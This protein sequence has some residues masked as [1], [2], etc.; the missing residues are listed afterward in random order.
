MLAMLVELLMRMVQRAADPARLKRLTA[1][2]RAAPAMSVGSGWIRPYQSRRVRW[3]IRHAYQ[4]SPFYRERLDRLGIRP[5]DVQQPEDLH[6]LPLTWPEDLREWDRFLCVPVDSAVAVFTSAGTT[7]E[8]KRVYFSQGD[9][10][11]L[12]HFGALAARLRWVGP[13]TALIVLPMRHGLWIGWNT[14]LRVVER[15]GGLPLPVGGEDLEDALRWLQRFEPQIIIA[16]PTHMM[17]L[18]RAAQAAGYRK[19]VP[20][21]LLG[22]EPLDA[23]REG[24]F[25]DYWQAQIYDSYGATEIGGA[26][27]IRMPGC[28]AFHLNDL[29]L[30]T[31]IVDPASGLPAQEGVLAFTTLRREAMP[32]I[33]YVVGDRAVRSPCVC[34]LQTTTI[35]LQGRMD[36]LIIVADQALSG[37]GIL[38]ALAPLSPQ[39]EMRVE[40]CVDR[41]QGVDRLRL[42]ISAE[43][44]SAERVR[45]S[46]LERYTGLRTVLEQGLLT[47]E[48]ETGA[49]LADPLK[50]FRLRDLRPWADGGRAESPSARDMGGEPCADRG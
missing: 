42:S 34:G 19:P 48:I 9:L 40:C 47:L 25:A 31:E 43:G 12:I 37:Q 13:M 17:G 11:S 28:T 27:S 10:Q 39:A 3:T 7:G 15:A 5:R 18:T 29:H 50:P 30:L 35:A 26:Q 4:K 1:M 14:A 33:R 46:L 2:M 49:D 21:I 41:V 32:L 44:L 8:P 6:R 16:S 24:L 38:D 20:V 36:D 23:E 22:G 45:R